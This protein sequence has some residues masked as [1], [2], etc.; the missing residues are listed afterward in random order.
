MGAEALVRW[1]DEEGF[2]VGP[3]VFVKLA[4]ER[5]FVGA[6]TRLVPRNALQDFGETLRSHPGFHL[7]INVAAADLADPMFL[8]TLNR[9]LHQAGV[10]PSSLSVEITESGTA[11]SRIAMEAILRLRGKG[12]NVLID[13][14]GTGYSSLAY[15]QDLS[16]DAIK[17]DQAFTKAIGTEAV[18]AAILPQ[19]LAMAA[20]LKLDV[21]VE[22]IETQ[23]QADYFAGAG[24]RILA[25][26][27]LF[28]RPVPAE[29]FQRLVVEDREVAP[30]P[31]DADLSIEDSPLEPARSLTYV[32]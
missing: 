9:S 31:I 20:A 4:E 8:P 32:N 16:V 14:F 22:G 24:E 25:Q 2:A 26:G 1:T 12:H 7:S 18:T 19:I 5:G 15:L 23:L 13:D 6:I 10:S 11:R 29:I 21:V 3:N 17:I 27:W 30:T 28:G